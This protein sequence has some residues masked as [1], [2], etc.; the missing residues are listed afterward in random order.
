MPTFTTT[1]DL[2]KP[3]VNSAVDEDLWGGQL[4]DNADTLDQELGADFVDVA[5]AAT[6]AIGSAASRNVRITGTTTITSFGTSN[7]GV[8]RRVRFAD[9]LTLTHNGTSLILPGGAN[10]TTVADDS[11][12]SA[13]LR[14]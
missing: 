12:I 9:A 11:L 2:N 10:I 1:Y 5:S 8:T 7:A 6:T 14:Q 4:N 3:L 13:E